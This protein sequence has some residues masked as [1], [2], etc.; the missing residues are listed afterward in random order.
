MS[1][2]IRKLKINYQI[3]ITNPK[4]IK[5]IMYV[6]KKLFPKQETKDIML[7]KGLMSLKINLKNTM[8]LHIY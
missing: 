2:S 3:V 8:L 1:K 5:K 7:T 6:Y 4:E